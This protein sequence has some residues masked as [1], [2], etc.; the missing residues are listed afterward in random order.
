MTGAL[1]L[2]A[3]ARAA[4]ADGGVGWQGLGTDGGQVVADREFRREINIARL[5][6]GERAF[7]I[8]AE[9]AERAALAARLRIER[10][11]RLVAHGTVGRIE[12]EPLLVVKGR[13]EAEVTQLCVVTLEPVV[14]HLTADIYRI[15]ALGGK[16][17][18]REIVVDPLLDEPE[19]LEG[20]VLDLG[21]IVAEELALALDPYPRAPGAERSPA[22]PV[23]GDGWAAG[24]RPAAGG[25]GGRP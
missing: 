20:A 7:A 18:E 4:A 15:F 16:A 17:A 11:D 13:L 3:V 1:A 5:P 14:S 23:A 12:G 19:P 9:P 10:I 21:E 6:I 8:A 22:E 24:A 25:R 2:L